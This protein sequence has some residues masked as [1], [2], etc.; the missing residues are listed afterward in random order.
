MLNVDL[1]S[2]TWLKNNTPNNKKHRYH[3]VYS[4]YAVADIET[5][6][7][8]GKELEG[9]SAGDFNFVNGS[10]K[11]DFLAWSYQ[12]GIALF[13]SETGQL[14][15]YDETRNIT[16]FVS[17]IWNIS[18]ELHNVSYLS[19][20]SGKIIIY[21]HNLKFDIM[22]FRKL[23]LTLWQEQR[24]EV[25][26]EDFLTDNHA[27]LYFRIENIEFRCSWRLTGQSLY[28]FTKEMAVQHRKIL[29][30]NDY[31]VHY[32]DEVLSQ[33]YTDYMYNDVVGLG[34]AL[35]TFMQIEGL[36]L[37]ELPYTS[38]GFPRKYV[39]NEFKQDKASVLAFK[40]SQ[41]SP[42][43]YMT[44]CGA[45]SGGMT[46]ANEKYAGKVVRGHIK[47]RDFVSFYPSMM[48]T[49]LYPT[50]SP[51]LVPIPEDSLEAMTLLYNETYRDDKLLAARVVV[52]NFAK[53]DEV[54][55][56]L[57][58]H[59]FHSINDDIKIRET[60]SHKVKHCLGAAYIDT[61]TP[62]LMMMYEYAKIHP[63]YK[64]IPL[65]I[66]EYQA[67]RLPQPI[68]NAIKHYFY[69]KSSYKMAVKIAKKKGNY[70]M[71]AEL[72][73]KLQRAK[74][75][76]NGLYG[77]LVEQQV[78]DGFTID[79][80]GNVKCTHSDLTDAVKVNNILLKYYGNASKGKCLS[81]LHG[82]YITAWAKYWLFKYCDTIGWD[83]VLYVDTDSAFYLTSPAVEAAIDQLNNYCRAVAI[84]TDAFI[85]YD[86]EDENGVQQQATEYLHWFDDEHEDITIFKAL[87]AKRYLYYD[88]ASGQLKLTA[89]G[90]A[91]GID[92]VERF[93]SKGN[94]FAMYTYTREME[95][96]GIKYGE[97]LDSNG[98]PIKLTMDD[99]E[100]AFENFQC[101]YTDF[102]HMSSVANDLLNILEKQEN[103]KPLLDI[104]TDDSLPDRLLFKKSSLREIVPTVFRK[105]GGTTA[106]YC[107]FEPTVVT[108]A[109]HDIVTEG[110]IGIYDC[111][112][113]LK[114]IT[115]DE[116]IL[117][118]LEDDNAGNEIIDLI[119]TYQH[120]GG[121]I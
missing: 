42:Y 100:R 80:L 104:P 74:A 87:N 112:K 69:L 103:F 78:R 114:A 45:Y 10:T 111:V 46:Q 37:N 25:E 96:A 83:N 58:A 11:L 62:E 53:S 72:N 117:D 40:M 22:F 61:T 29:G 34:E 108:V 16:D 106:K 30:A 52:Y 109:G 95:L 88:S 66:Y 115:S 73:A 17:N 60:Y 113:Q 67:A 9:V 102:E 107:E 97:H 54:M 121:K 41:P 19:S 82:T 76:L 70:N 119:R 13:N 51:T 49:Q 59:R 57:P 86:Y 99:I 93:D 92:K 65:V 89:A 79:V 43:E 24:G 50:G 32:P 21:I 15:S 36:K 44:W 38:T 75:K 56:F 81:Y 33:E 7:I 1:S 98:D 28:D 35:Y 55:P 71:L 90:I 18:Q 31:G 118:E 4:I 8:D 101:S 116:F 23:L 39:M 5:S 64:I 12:Q 77:M 6:Y 85:T 2:G 91:A 110:G 48:Y 26:F 105:C 20:K 63:E 27:W 3:D 94:P 84:N 47:H 120:K 68:L 14:I